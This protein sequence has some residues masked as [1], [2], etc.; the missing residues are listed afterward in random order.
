MAANSSGDTQRP[1][2]TELRDKAPESA[3]AAA[4]TQLLVSARLGDTGAIDRLFVTLYR[5]LHRLARAK[6]RKHRTINGLDTTTVL[7][8]SYVRLSRLSSLN[9]EDRNHFFT[10]AARVMRS[11]IVDMV[12]NA[13]AERRGGGQMHVTLST[14]V[15][16]SVA[17]DDVLDIHRALDELEA[18]EPR[19]VRVVEARFFGGLTEIETAEALGI[20]DRTVRRDWEK[21]K[22]MIASIIREK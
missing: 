11:V 2:E 22:I 8:E 3:E 19:L 6:L 7:H 21:A 12:R 16:N 18:V 4:V 20:S 1:D 13:Q 15:A 17:E 5:E 10:Y 14:E 9:V